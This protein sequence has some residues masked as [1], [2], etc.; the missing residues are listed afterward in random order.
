MFKL[1]T[2][3][4]M[5]SIISI[6]MC[7]SILYENNQALKGDQLM[8]QSIS[9]VYALAK[10]MDF[11]C[12]KTGYEDLATMLGLELIWEEE[13]LVPSPRDKE[14][15]VVGETNGKKI[16]LYLN[17]CDKATKEVFFHEIGHVKM[18]HC[19]PNSMLSYAAEEGEADYFAQEMIKLLNQ[20]NK[21]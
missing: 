2:L 9:D 7:C 15:R 8:E 1:S 21:K 17:R 18:R 19:R 5:F 16:Y 10:H 11:F 6:T 14:K 12:S 13:K 3:S 4:I 20:Q